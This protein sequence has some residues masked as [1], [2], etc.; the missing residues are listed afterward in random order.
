VAQIVEVLSCWAE[1][2]SSLLKRGGVYNISNMACNE[3]LMVGP[4]LGNAFRN[5]NRLL[6]IF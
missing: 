2:S 5:V 1:L 4:V 3:N 6:Y